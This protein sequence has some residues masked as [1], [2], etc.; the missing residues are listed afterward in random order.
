[1]C[2]VC[3]SVGCGGVG[4]VSCVLLQCCGEGGSVLCCALLFAVCV[5]S[6]LGDVA[7]GDTSVTR[8]S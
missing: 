8:G 1:V 3:C 2:A 7:C 6:L 5:F 4:C